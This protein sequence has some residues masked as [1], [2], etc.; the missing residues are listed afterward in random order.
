MRQTLLPSALLPLLLVTLPAAA[1]FESIGKQAK[2]TPAAPAAQ[3]APAAPAAPATPPPPLPGAAPAKA[4]SKAPAAKS[5]PERTK[6]APQVTASKSSIAYLE[7]MEEIFESG[8][9]GGNR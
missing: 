4:S 7:A 9:P 3:A 5:Q 1:Q 8:K 2:P 6:T